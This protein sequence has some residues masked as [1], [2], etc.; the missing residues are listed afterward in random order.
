MIKVTGGTL[1][2]LLRER[3]LSRG[4]STEAMADAL[5]IPERQYLTYEKADDIIPDTATVKKFSELLGVTENEVWSACIGAPGEEVAIA[6]LADSMFDNI[7]NAKEESS[8]KKE[9]SPS[10]SANKKEKQPEKS[11]GDSNDDTVIAVVSKETPETPQIA[12]AIAIPRVINKKKVDD[13]RKKATE[14]K[15]K[16]ASKKQ[17]SEKVLDKADASPASKPNNAQK[18]NNTGKEIPLSKDE[19]IA[20]DT[21]KQATALQAKDVDTTK[22]VNNKPIDPNESRNHILAAYTANKAISG[23][24]AGVVDKGPELFAVFLVEGIPVFV[25]MRV[26]AETN[27]EALNK[28]QQE[29]AGEK[30]E[31]TMRETMLHYVK[32]RIGMVSKLFITSANLGKDGD[33]EFYGN[34][35]AAMRDARRI[36]W[37]DSENTEK[38]P[39]IA[40]SRIR[41]DS[42]LPATIVTVTKKIVRIEVFGAETSIDVSQMVET[43]LGDARIVFHQGKTI[44]ATIVDF[45]RKEGS[46]NYDVKFA[47]T[48]KKPVDKM[49]ESYKK[50]ETVDGVVTYIRAENP[51]RLSKVFISISRKIRC[52]CP[53]PNTKAFKPP[54][55]G[56]RVRAT[57]TRIGNDGRLYG[58]I[59]FVDDGT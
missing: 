20:D 43:E 33:T 21:T 5:N 50:G 52:V 19:P 30:R 53:W 18:E 15:K 55:K 2:T 14:S 32:A 48:I 59:T 3:R 31:I 34:R 56:S 23:S 37:F 35:V 44:Q 51:V 38:T 16:A 9:K 26:L 45:E 47:A 27:F 1:H 13:E 7:N 57:V 58:Y 11:N 24:L 12:V 8:T 39:N 54:I 41:K 36:H 22:T 4:L 49:L 40:T 29:I 25:P 17:K 42:V 46:D 10:P 6:A 28:R